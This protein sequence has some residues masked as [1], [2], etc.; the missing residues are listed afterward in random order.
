[1]RP[2]QLLLLKSRSLTVRMCWSSRGARVKRWRGHS[3]VGGD[4]V[5]RRGSECWIAT[6][7]IGRPELS[8]G[9]PHLLVKGP[10]VLRLVDLAGARADSVDGLVHVAGFAL[11]EGKSV[12]DTLAGALPAPRR[13]SAARTPTRCPRAAPADELTI[14]PVLVPEPANDSTVGGRPRPNGCGRRRER[15]RP[16][17]PGPPPWQWRQTGRTSA[18]ASRRR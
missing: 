4:V 5:V 8:A 11:E 7:A 6:R 17:A 15:T 14:A 18:P 16:A 12:G 3:L 10:A 9:P 2:R 1:V 13:G